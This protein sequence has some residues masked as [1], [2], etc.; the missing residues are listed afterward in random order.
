[1]NWNWY[2]ILLTDYSDNTEKYKDI[3]FTW[4]MSVCSLL[5]VR[6]KIERNIACIHAY[7]ILLTEYSDNT[8][9]YKDINFT[10]LMSVCSVYL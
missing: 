2:N 9:K 10:W 5:S 4:V 1:M 8:E 7:N 6:Q 3:N